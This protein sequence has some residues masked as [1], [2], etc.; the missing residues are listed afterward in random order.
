[1]EKPK[2]KSKMFYIGAKVL[3]AI[4]AIPI[5]GFVYGVSRLVVGGWFLPQYVVGCG[6]AVAGLTAGSMILVKKAEK[7]K[8]E[9]EANEQK[10][11]DEKM[12][13]MVA[14]KMKQKA[15]TKEEDGKSTS[16]VNQKPMAKNDSQKSND[17]E[18]GM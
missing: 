16:K 14:E 1:M 6:V 18:M 8:K 9:A 11:R 15:I 17:N 4:N 13:E 3:S 12:A 10:V 7:L 5:A 2:D